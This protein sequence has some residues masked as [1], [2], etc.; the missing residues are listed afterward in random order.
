MPSWKGLLLKV[1]PNCEEG[2][3]LVIR[4]KV[5]LGVAHQIRAILQSSML[6][7]LENPSPSQEP[8]IINL[9]TWRH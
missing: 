4:M 1:G 6:T 2:A 8:D 9:T 7:K 3:H 5:S